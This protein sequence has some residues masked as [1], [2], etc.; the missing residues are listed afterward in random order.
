M[1]STVP[2]TRPG[3]VGQAGAGNLPGNSFLPPHLAANNGLVDRNVPVDRLA[4]KP[5]GQL[6]EHRP[7]SDAECVDRVPGGVA[8]R[9]KSALSKQRQRAHDTINQCLFNAASVEVFRNGCH[10]AYADLVD[11]EGGCLNQIA[12]LLEMLM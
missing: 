6:V 8:I 4:A 7:G 10:H 5:L 9:P 11:L 3:P 12:I 1:D 2:I